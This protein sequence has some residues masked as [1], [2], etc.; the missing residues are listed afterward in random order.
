MLALHLESLIHACDDLGM[1]LDHGGVVES[2]AALP[3]GVL[4]GDG[5][6]AALIGHDRQLHFPAVVAARDAS[7]WVEVILDVEPAGKVAH[8]ANGELDDV[9][10]TADL[11]R[12][13][14]AFHE[15][16]GAE[17]FHS[18]DTRIRRAGCGSCSRRNRGWTA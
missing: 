9:A 4:E 15:V 2:V 10:A 3:V 1:E 14:D 11:H 16:V 7:G 13:A 5:L 12:A 8:G 6:D 17:S 18:R